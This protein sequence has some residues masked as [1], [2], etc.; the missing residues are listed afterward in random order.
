MG[1]RDVMAFT[2]LMNTLTPFEMVFSI[3]KAVSANAISS[4]QVGHCSKELLTQAVLLKQSEFAF[5]LDGQTSAVNDF[6]GH[7]ARDLLP[8][9]EIP[10]QDKHI[11]VIL[12]LGGANKLALRFDTHHPFPACTYDGQYFKA[13]YAF[14]DI[15]LDKK[16]LQKARQEPGTCLWSGFSMI[17]PNLRASVLRLVLLHPALLMEDRI[18][19]KL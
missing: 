17:F 13:L 14:R 10:L 18:I 7:L 9:A 19:R 5:F 3:V 4:D 15:W 12:A 6:C 11:G 2:A 8:S 1:G 16:P